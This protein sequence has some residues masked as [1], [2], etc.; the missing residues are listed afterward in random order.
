LEEK[1]LVGVI[2][3][4]FCKSGSK[5]LMLIPSIISEIIVVT[6]RIE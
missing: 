6:L 5:N 3:L 2:N 4:G 1:Y